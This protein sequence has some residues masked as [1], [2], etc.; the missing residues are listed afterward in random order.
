MP[1][2]KQAP[3]AAQSV[4]M[5]DITLSKT[6]NAHIRRQLALLGYSSLKAYYRSERWVD[7]RRKLRR[8][9][10]ARCGARR[11]LQVHHRTYIRLGWELQRDVVTLCVTCHRLEHGLV[12]PKVRPKRRKR[13]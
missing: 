7:S 11:R 1:V 2:L 10:C 5:A 6:Q 3:V 8:T 13:S 12:K 9:T 4:M